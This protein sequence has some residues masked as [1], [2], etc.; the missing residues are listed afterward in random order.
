MKHTDTH[1]NMH[2]DEPIIPPPRL[3]NFIPLIVLFALIILFTALM[4]VSLGFWN[5]AFAMQNFMASFFIIFGGF[6]LMNWRGFVNA[7][8]IYDIIAKRSRLYAYLYPLLEIGLGI[9]YLFALNLILTNWI[10]IIVM[11]ISSVGVAQELKNKNQIP[12]AC[13]G[14]VF[15]IPMTRVTFAKDIL[16]ATMALWMLLN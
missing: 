14:I 8:S 10:T 11:I 13:L 7:Y 5:T 3:R 1:N 16:M 2:I 12:C 9:S 15:K 4:Q 6:K